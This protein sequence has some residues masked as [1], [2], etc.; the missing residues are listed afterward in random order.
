MRQLRLVALSDDGAHLILSDGGDEQ[1]VL[2]VDERLHAAIR[3]D[4]AR[5]GQLE[6]Q[7][8][9]QLRPRDIQARI[10][11]GESVQS[12]A[13]LSG[14][15]LDKVERFA[16]PVIAERQH[17]SDRARQATVRRL[18]GEGKPPTLDSVASES[19][20][21][22]GVDPAAITWDAWRRDDGR[23]IVRCEWTVESD[24]VFATFSFEPTGRSVVP[25]DDAAR[26]LAGEMAPPENPEPSSPSRPVEPVPAPAPVAEPPA[27]ST[28]PPDNDPDD[29][30]ADIPTGPARLSV[31]QGAR[32]DSPAA[33]AAP[34]VSASADVDER[35]TVDD[36]PAVVGDD[37]RRSSRRPTPY[38][39]SDRRRRHAEP[40]DHEPDEE[41]TSERLRLSDIAS[42]VQTEGPTTAEMEPVYDTS[43]AVPAEAEPT[44][45]EEPEVPVEASAPPA[46]PPEPVAPPEIVEEAPAEHVEADTQVTG[47]PQTVESPDP[48]DTQHD[49]AANAPGASEKPAKKPAAKRSKSKR[50]SV[51][52]WDEI[53][54]G[55]GKP[56]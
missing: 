16:G 3:G 44:V 55:R 5:L 1:L 34:P 52:S 7:L 26:L 45:P 36:R 20:R 42:K 15:P 40:P 33:P 51:P 29:F 22:H 6:I 32:D 37:M 39:R 54:F 19:A 2:Q 50:P 13:A 25:E 4:R 46:A 30:V 17:I 48:T 9:S 31:V 14:M 35:P 27:S 8:E 28:P 10:R 11:S 23:W 18:Q 47:A 49:E 21:A 38:G 12:V 53:M 24:E 43:P 41:A 56:E